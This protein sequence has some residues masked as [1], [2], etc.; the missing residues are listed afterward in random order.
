[1]IKNR[2]VLI[3]SFALI[4]RAFY[5]LPPSLTKDGHPINAAYGFTAAL[6]AAIKEL[7]PEYLV[8]AFDLPKPT[9][10]KLEYVEYK[11]HRKPMP[12]DLVPQIQYC[13]EVLKE[14]NIPLLAVEGYE[15]EDIIA[16][17][18][19]QL[20]DSSSKDQVESIIV[21][22]DSDTFQLINEHTTVYSMARGAQQA[23]IYDEKKMFER[24]GL[25]PSQFIDFK[26]LKGDAS[27]NIPG[28]PGVGEKTAAMLIDKFGSLDE[29]YQLISNSQFLISNQISNHN[30]QNL[31]IE[32]SVKIENCKIENLDPEM[33]E[34]TSKTLK[35]SK[36]I[37]TLLIEYHD[38]AYLSQKLA[39]I[40]KDAPLDF[41]LKSA[42][43]HDF[44]KEK[45]T[46]L[47]T[48]LGFKSLIA[49]LPN[50]TRTNNQL[51]LF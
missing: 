45:V 7:E 50:S 38:Q 48:N 15:G 26:A 46:K 10:R 11:A 49:R 31:N 2:L 51:G 30:F 17:I 29:L 34:K 36:K 42:R 43:V 18:I 32:N 9:K 14:M 13:R 12:D 44:D 27:D 47:F 6:L 40:V 25:K 4:F 33:L 39:T 24:Y 23:T 37:L 1:M 28:V 16:T 19:T 3:D 8:A 20:K 22:G 5:G 21:T 41:D 35:I